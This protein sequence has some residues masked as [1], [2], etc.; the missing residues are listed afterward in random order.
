M[1]TKA[2]SAIFSRELRSWM[3]TPLFY[4]WC[5]S[6]LLL[7]AFFFFSLLLQFNGVLR[8]AAMVPETTTSL[9]EWV[10]TPLF[11]TLQIV[12]VFFIPLMTMRLLAEE[13]RSGTF[14]LLK[15]SPVSAGAI[16]GG[17]YLALLAVVA[18]VILLSGVFPLS[19]VVYSNPEVGPIFT[20]IV[21]LVLF[22]AAFGAI[23]LFVSTLC[24]SQTLAG[25]LSLVVFLVLYLIDTPA[26]RIG[27]PIASLL[28]YLTPASHTESF[29][30]G[31]LDGQDVLYFL[32]AI[33]CGVFLAIRSLELD[34][35]K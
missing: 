8:Q 12:L 16:V 6:F 19:L 35:L 5:S 20:G 21:G 23:G 9:N 18:G 17:K 27:G 24:S 33:F 7:T 28:T 1:S 2:T 30:H 25:I 10:V 32:S 11:G 22:S 4:V 15:T 34:R 3:V 29:E 26:E 13:R 14:T 31:V